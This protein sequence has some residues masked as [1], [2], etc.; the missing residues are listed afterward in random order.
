MSCDYS[1]FP[2]NGATR[3]NS[4]SSLSNELHAYLKYTS[5]SSLFLNLNHQR[6]SF[7]DSL[8]IVESQRWLAFS[9]FTLF[10]ISS[11]ATSESKLDYPTQFS[12]QIFKTQIFRLTRTTKIT[13][14][15]KNL[16]C[17]ADKNRLA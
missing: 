13:A 1:Y 11:N 8:S 9:A 17:C 12:V 7:K 5:Y 10:S 3:S 2:S 16:V 4:F 15:T 14:Q 6:V